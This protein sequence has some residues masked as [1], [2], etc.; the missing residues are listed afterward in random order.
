MYIYIYIYIYNQFLLLM[1][2]YIDEY[3]FT[4]SIID[5]HGICTYIQIYITSKVFGT[6]G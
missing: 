2:L 4:H 1:C 3:V 5:I 6:V